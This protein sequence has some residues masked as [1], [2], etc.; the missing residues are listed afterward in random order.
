MVLLT[1]IFLKYSNYLRYRNAATSD[2][3]RGWIF[4]DAVAGSLLCASKKHFLITFTALAAHLDSPSR[5]ATSPSIYLGQGLRRLPARLRRGAN[6]NS[7]QEQPHPE[8]GD[9]RFY[10]RLLYKEQPDLKGRQI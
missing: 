3:N 8:A 4:V 5:R 10:S 2:T 7:H 9:S 1:S 6:N